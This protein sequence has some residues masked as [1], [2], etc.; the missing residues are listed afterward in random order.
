M[1]DYEALQ[2]DTLICDD[3]PRLIV[4]MTSKMERHHHGCGCCHDD[5]QVSTL[6]TFDPWAEPKLVILA[7][8]GTTHT[9]PLEQHTWPPDDARIIRGGVQIWPCTQPE[10]ETQS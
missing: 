5:H 2:G 4:G 1:P 8:G 9:W 10:T 7:G 3:T 6:W